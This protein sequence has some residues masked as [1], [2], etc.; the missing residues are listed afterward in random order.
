MGKVGIDFFFQYRVWCP[1]CMVWGCLL[2]FSAIFLKNE[3][4]YLLAKSLYFL[5]WGSLPG[6][7]VVW[8][9][10]VYVN[11]SE[12]ETYKNVPPLPFCISLSPLYPPLLCCRG[13]LLCCCVVSWWYSVR[14]SPAFFV[15]FF[16][17]WD[18]LTFG[19]FSL[20]FGG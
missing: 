18:S 19:L 13:V 16:K 9:M 7:V 3:G 10:V 17:K 4:L 15:D 11:V 6:G 2:C 8:V 5:G 20:T 1:G 12:H 14:R